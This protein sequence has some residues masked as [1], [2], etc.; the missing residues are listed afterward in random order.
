MP[1]LSLQKK[2]QL[3]RCYAA[4]EPGWEPSSLVYQNL[5]ASRLCSNSVVLDL[6]CG[7]GGV[8]ERLHSGAGL[9]VGLDPDVH[10]LRD[11]RE[12][13]LALMA[14]RGRSLPVA[15]A[16]CAVVATSWVLEHLSAPA[17]ALAEVARVLGPGGSLIFL[18]PNARNP[19]VTM[20]RFVGRLQTG[21]VAAA[22]GRDGADT[23]PVFYRANTVSRIDQLARSAGLTRRSVTEVGD[24]TYLAFNRPLFAM[25]RLLERLTP[26]SLKVHLVGEYVK[27]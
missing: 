26:G 27:A 19:L 11:H 25:S 10:S 16:T 18:T 24:P 1:M 20:N 7:R 6:G 23:Y 2:E 12:A 14:G 5:V 17:Q 13:A 21:L 15:D 9:S 4:M 22:Y 8:L 3:R